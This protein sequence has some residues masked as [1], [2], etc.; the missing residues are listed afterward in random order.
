[1]LSTLGHGD[2][3][4]FLDRQGESFGLTLL[5]NDTLLHTVLYTALASQDAL[6]VLFCH[7]ANIIKEFARP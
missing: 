4:L 7:P 3:T 6:T 1:M 5:K 2:R